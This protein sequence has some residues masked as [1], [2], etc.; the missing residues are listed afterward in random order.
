M[1]WISTSGERKAVGNHEMKRGHNY[2]GSMTMF[3]NIYRVMS[4]VSAVPTDAGSG[5]GVVV[6]P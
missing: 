1:A 5:C 6:V 4:A 2:R 3:E